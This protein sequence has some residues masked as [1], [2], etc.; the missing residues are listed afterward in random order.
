MV[1]NVQSKRVSEQASQQDGTRFFVER[2][3]PRGVAK[4]ALDDAAWLGEVAI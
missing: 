1:N 2:L 4:S 3:W